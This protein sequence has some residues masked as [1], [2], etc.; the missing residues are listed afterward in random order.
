MKNI[1][2]RT[3]H[4]IKVIIGRDIFYRIQI[5]AITKWYGNKNAGFYVNSKSLNSNSIVYSFG[6]GEDISFDKGLL[7]E[8]NCTVYGFDPTPKT[9]EYIENENV[10]DNFI[11]LPYGIYNLDGVVNFYL[12]L[13]PNHVSCTISN[14]QNY[15]QNENKFVEV[16]VKTF[17]T[18]VAELGHKKI[19]ILKLDIEGS[20]YEVLDQIL[21]SPIEIGQILIEFH[22]RFPTI[23]KSK[24]K[25]AI[26]KLNTSGYKLAAISE[27]YEEFTFIKTKS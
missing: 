16:P 22:H 10:P 7:Q 8:F 12:P 4:L 14:I 17:S 25:E 5:K 2:S 9:I 1:K 27:Q 23:H 19:D 13:N 26:K 11:F 18:I 6:I 3:K 15:D 20:E 24:T 21:N